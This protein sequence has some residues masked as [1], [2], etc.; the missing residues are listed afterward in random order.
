L[1][2]GR[3]LHTGNASYPVDSAWNAN[4]ISQHAPHLTPTRLPY[5]AMIPFTVSF[6][7][8]HLCTGHDL[9]Q[10]ISLPASGLDGSRGPIS[11]VFGVQMTDGFAGAVTVSIPIFALAAGAE[12][13]AIRDR[14]KRP[15]EKWEREFADYDSAHELDPGGSAAEVFEYFKG[16]PRLSKLHTAERLIAL[17]GAIVWLTVFVLLT[18]AE[19]MSLVWLADGDPAGHGGL[20]TFCVVSVALTM[21]ALIVAPAVYLAVPLLLPLDLVPPGLTKALLP[22]ATSVRGR[23]FLRLMFAELE[24]AIDRAAAQD[25][26]SKEAGTSAAAQ[27]PGHEE[28]GAPAPHA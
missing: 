24:G 1:Q 19:L 23:G 15:D 20:A 22:Q 16:L 14:L 6:R 25:E 2:Q 3:I 26:A 5:A 28:P 7:Q 11:T 21:A 13:R 27:A 17:V 12:A 18:I 8:G 4:L 9:R 10:F